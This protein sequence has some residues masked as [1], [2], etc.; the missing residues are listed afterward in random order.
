MR[1]PTPPRG[2]WPPAATLNLQMSNRSEEVK[3]SDYKHGLPYICQSELGRH[4]D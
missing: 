4:F 1:P 2:N 3:G